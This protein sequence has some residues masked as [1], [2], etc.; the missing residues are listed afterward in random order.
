M[1]TSPFVKPVWP[2]LWKA[3]HLNIDWNLH[4]SPV[5]WHCRMNMLD[6]RNIKLLLFPGRAC[7][8]LGGTVSDIWSS[9]VGY[10]TV[11]HAS[12]LR[13][14]YQCKVKNIYR[15]KDANSS[16][17]T[18]GNVTVLIAIHT[19]HFDTNCCC[20]VLLRLKPPK[21][22]WLGMTCKLI[23]A[24]SLKVGLMHSLEQTRKTLKSGSAD[25]QMFS[26]LKTWQFSYCF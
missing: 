8:A 3:Y 14:S 10:I 18:D 4:L 16:S 5:N 2:C 13:Q 17:G 6:M 25:E 22:S 20:A 1:N 7:G 23:S 12:R 9:A 21:Q 15:D 26:F 11:Y 24:C 19:A